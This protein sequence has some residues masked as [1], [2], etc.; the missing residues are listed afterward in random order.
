MLKEILSFVCLNILVYTMMAVYNP[1]FKKKA[2]KNN[3]NNQNN[4]NQ[5]KNKR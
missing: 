1:L 3:Q 2:N 4:Q 5:N